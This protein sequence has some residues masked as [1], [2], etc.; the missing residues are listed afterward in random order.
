MRYCLRVLRMGLLLAL[1]G[2]LGQNV[3]LTVFTI[4]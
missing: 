4:P 2:F 3:V 1:G